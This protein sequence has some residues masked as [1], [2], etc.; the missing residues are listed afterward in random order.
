ME[1]RG[2]ACRKVPVIGSRVAL[3]PCSVATCT[4][5]ACH[6]ATHA[7]NAAVVVRAVALLAFVRIR[8][9]LGEELVTVFL[10]PVRLCMMTR[11]RVDDCARVS[12]AA[13][14]RG[15]QQSEEQ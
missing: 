8:G 10:D 1:F 2:R 9:V 7:G 12:A 5:E 3:R 15:Q 6:E 13:A 4:V 14:R 11:I